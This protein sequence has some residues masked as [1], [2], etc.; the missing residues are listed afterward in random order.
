MPTSRNTVALGVAAGV[1]VGSVAAW[2]RTQATRPKERTGT[3][4]NGIEYAALGGGPR[5]ML[6]L[7]GGPGTPSWD[8]AQARSFLPRYALGAFTVYWLSRRRN[9][10][11]G[12]TVAD[13][14]DDVA[15]V[16]AELGGRVDAVV[17]ASYGGLIAIH[18]AAR[19][20]DRVGRVV[21]LASAA[22]IPAE[23]KEMDRRWGHGQFTEAGEGMLAAALPG[24]HLG[25]V[26]HLFAPLAGRMLASSRRNLG[27]VLVETQAEMDYDARSVVPQI[28]AP[29]LIVAGDRDIFLPR[30]VIERTA[31]GIRDC[32][33]VWHHGHGHV[34]TI[35][36]RRTTN[37]VLAFLDA[38]PSTTKHANPK[39]SMGTPGLRA[40][41]GNALERAAWDWAVLPS[42]PLGRMSSTW[43]MPRM[44]GPIYPVMGEALSLR[45]EDEL[46][47]IACGSG[48]F[49][50]QQAEHVRRIAGL[51]LS[52]IQVDLACQR[53]AGR[54]STGTA[55]I[56]RG[57]AS[58]LPWPDDSFTVVTC[59][60][61]FE[62][63][64]DPE[65][66][67][68]EVL[69]VLRPGGR[70]VL[71]IGEQVPPGT[72]TRQVLGGVWMWAEDDVRRMVEQ[73][74]FTDVSL[75]YAD[76]SG[77]GWLAKA[78]SKLP[79]SQALRLVRGTKP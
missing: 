27:D 78:G 11:A 77:N 10:P 21:L 49:L 79:W 53:L 28:T 44:H 26:R 65:L 74:G 63:F 18:L 2:R 39:G 13:M 32:T 33:V 66:V 56:V 40:S 42:G 30:E 52:D 72:Q 35:R 38:Q 57:D 6:F 25:W 67:L 64:Q 50:A 43:V 22:M 70:A 3:F 58:A 8:K 75:W 59:M 36:S 34:R 20:P 17:G 12:H 19:H 68:A 60:G 55:E 9:M 31:A 61:S 76:A 71:N 48:V 37:D 54:I 15:G 45:P 41:V 51:D 7:P 14:A 5:T 16:I 1:A 47:E 24:Q 62:G 46:L 29:V 73:A 4:T 23:A 69:R